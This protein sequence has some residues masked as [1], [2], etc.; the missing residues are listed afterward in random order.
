MGYLFLGISIFAGLTKGFCGKKISNL[1]ESY[2]DAMLTNFIRMLLCIVIGF[3]IVAVSGDISGLLI[4]TD[5]LFACMLSGFST[6]FFVIFWIITVK[7]GAYMLLEVFLM[8]GV[9][10]TTVLC[11]IFFN[12]DIRINQYIGF[13]ILIVAAYL[14]C[15]YNVSLKGAFTFKSAMLLIACA[16]G[17]SLTDFSQKLYVETVSD[18][19]TAVFNFYT[20]VFSSAILFVSYIICK[21]RDKGTF[22]ADIGLVKGVFGTVVIMAI[23]LFMNSFFKVLAAKELD[24]VTLFPLS[25]GTA[26]ILSSLMAAVFFKEKPNAKSIAGMISAFIGLLVINIL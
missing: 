6:S 26:L 14:M 4:D 16:I 17:I 3:G 10:L 8:L 21:V 15:S 25:Q 11:K 23:C 9:I 13:V 24:A 18:S 1:V 7:K 2:K 5:S 12:E 22:S 20:Y 19:D